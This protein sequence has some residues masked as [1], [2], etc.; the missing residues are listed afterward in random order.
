MNAAGT[1]LGIDV[2]SDVVCPWCFVGKAQLARA[3]DRLRSERPEVV[4][5]VAWHPYLLNPD[6]PREGEA[7]RPFL[8]RKFGGPAAVEAVWQ[9]VREA[10][11]RAGVDFAFEKIATRPNTLDAH[12][13]IRWQGGR[14][15]AGPLVDALFAAHFQRGQDIGDAATLAGIAAA[16]TGVAAA[17]VLA[18]LHT[19]AERAAVIDEVEVAARLGVR[20]VP[21][22]ILGRRLSVS[23][24]QG[25]EALA[26]ALRE[27]LG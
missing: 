26:A 2:V 19:D 25:D 1:T 16:A 15:D 24:A 9:R 17:D 21:C 14:G 11:A 12:R 20:S 23:G 3:I 13:L 4:F 18:W 8:E 22:F 10:G 27:A 5:Q 6:T 7:Y